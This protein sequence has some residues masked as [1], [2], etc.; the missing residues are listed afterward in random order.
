MLYEWLVSDGA[1]NLATVIGMSVAVFALCVTACQISQGTK[2]SRCQFWLELEKMFAQHD[3]VHTKLR[4]GGEWTRAGAGPK[5]IN[6]WAEVEDYMGLF[7]HCE[8][9]LRKGLLDAETF[10]TIFSYRLTNIIRNELI[11]KAKLEDEK[12]YWQTFLA[13]MNRFKITGNQ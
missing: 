10:K 9:M 12:V 7:E 2:I 3:E 8:F 1:A 6:E 11:Y 4:P 13:L 5:T